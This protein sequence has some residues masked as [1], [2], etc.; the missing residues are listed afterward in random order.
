VRD[1]LIGVALIFRDAGLGFS[2][3]ATAFFA[4]AIAF[5]ALFA[6]IPL[7]LLIVAMFGY[8]FG[9]ADGLAYA[10]GTMDAYVPQLHDLVTQSLASAVR[11]RGISGL[12]GLGGLAWSAKNVFGATTFALDRALG[13]P[14]R[15][16]VLEM[17]IALILIPV[18]GLVILIATAIPIVI[19]FIVHF[20]GLEYLRIAPQIASYGGSLVLVFVLSALVYT[21]LPN[22]QA[23]FRFGVPGAVVT[24]I[25]YSI[26]QVTF[27]VYTTHTNVLEIY[28]TL[29]A[30]FAVM[31]WI[32][33]NCALF[34]YGAHF[35]ACWEARF[36]RPAVREQVAS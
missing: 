10:V 13:V 29:S 18:V 16:F 32:Y 26:I 35:S 25:G 34:L 19:S 1:R 20:T 27:A 11:Y 9:T 22:R 24:A 33:L 21:Y 4:Q 23:S 2:L 12:V 3:E 36:D 8:I 6:V 30:V 14:S 17:A 15:H 28:G 31:L 5:S 7:S